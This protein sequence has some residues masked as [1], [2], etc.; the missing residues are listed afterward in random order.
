MLKIL[1]KEI[2]SYL[3]SLIAY[4]VISV[5]LTG[6]GLF[7]WI[8][9]DTNVLDYGFA[10]MSTLFTFAPYVFLFLIPAITMRLFAEEKK[11]GT[12][13][14]LFTR[15]LTDMQII[16]GKYFAGLL[17]VV[18]ALL[19]TLI[20]YYT[21]YQLGQVP[22]NID[23]AGVAGSYIGLLLLAAAFTAIG[24]FSSSLTVNQIVAFIIAVFLCFFFYIGFGSI[25]EIDVWGNASVVL[26]QLGILYHYNAM[27]KGL[28]DARNVVYLVSLTVLML[29]FTQLVIGSRKW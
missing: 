23:T 18:L 2:S 25:A 9:P 28:I 13:E 19:P 7:M 24:V 29:L 8:F 11:S 21:I 4:I 22:G 10:D 15:P 14:L 27:S 5:F 12:M 16:L 3:N 26:E 1:S 17:I 6:I 20:Y